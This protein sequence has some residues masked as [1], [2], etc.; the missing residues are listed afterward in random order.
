MFES[1]IQTYGYYAVFVFACIEGEIAVL[2]AGFLCKSGLMSLQFVIL[3]AFLG[4][5]VTEQCLFF[6]GRIYGAG[7]LEKYPKLS[8]KSSKVIEFLKKYDSAFI[9][10]SRFV[11]GIR[12]ISPIIIGVAKIT[13]LKFSTL[14]VPAA[15]IWSVSVAGAG[16]VFADVLESAKENLKY[17]QLGALAILCAAVAYFFI[18]KTDK[19]KSRRQPNDTR[20]K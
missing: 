10:G 2:T 9:F 6:V 20:K 12:N 14:N 13:P 7:L 18:R 3:F 5:L 15:F 8:Q 4:T 17:V 11:Y 19:K 16:Y 1:F